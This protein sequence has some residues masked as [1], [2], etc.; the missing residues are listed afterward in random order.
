MVRT[1]TIGIILST[2]LS[3]VYGTADVNHHED[4]VIENCILRSFVDDFADQVTDILFSCEQIG[5]N[6][7]ESSIFRIDYYPRHRIFEITVFDLEQA[8]LRATDS[9]QLY[10]EGIFRLDER[11]AQ[12]LIEGRF[13]PR[14][15]MVQMLL[16][17][18][19]Y[20]ALFADIGSSD[21]VRYR[22]NR[23]G[24]IKQ[25]EFPDNVSQIISEFVRRIEDAGFDSKR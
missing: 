15:G 11:P 2:I 8:T 23:R 6:D 3:T 14:V 22:V 18:G 12:R 10:P 24:N 13:S 1:T 21:I 17:G 20:P 4:L 19:D 5:E 7:N 25:V 9:G 16:E